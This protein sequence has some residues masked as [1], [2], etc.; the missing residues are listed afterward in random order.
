MNT[1]TLV[2]LIARRVMEQLYAL[3]GEMATNKPKSSVLVIGDCQDRQQL[4]QT[5]GN[6][7][8]L[9]Y[10]CDQQGTI[11]SNPD[12]FDHIVLAALPNSLLSALV[13][14]LERGSEGCVIIESLLLGKTIHILAEGIVYRRYRQ[15]A[16]PAFYQIF[17]NKEA[18]LCTFGMKVVELAQLAESFASAEPTVAEAVCQSTNTENV[19][20]M[21]QPASTTVQV[22]TGRVVSEK[23]LR[24]CYEQ[25][26]RC[27]KLQ[28]NA[29]ITPLAR[30]FLRLKTDL[31]VES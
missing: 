27:I 26:Y 21:S 4:E 14:G 17:A 16:N 6:D 23:D 24:A 8:Q 5:L 2:E 30:D 1:D 15:T 31:V 29:I 22:I 19:V 18:T 11:S 7:Y 12:E 13:I 9:S 25:G 28:E 10:I 20:Y 3:H